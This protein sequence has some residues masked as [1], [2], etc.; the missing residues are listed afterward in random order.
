MKK[1]NVNIFHAVMLKTYDYMFKSII[2][3]ARIVNRFSK[4]DAT[5]VALLR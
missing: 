5:I 4:S 1:L 2:A 3:F